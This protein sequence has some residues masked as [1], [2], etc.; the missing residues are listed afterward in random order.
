[1]AAYGLIIRIF[2]RPFHK[3]FIK[4]LIVEQAT[5]IERDLSLAGNFSTGVEI[6][7]KTIRPVGTWLVAFRD[8]TAPHPFHSFSLLKIMGAPGSPILKIRSESLSAKHEFIIGFD[9]RVNGWR[10]VCRYKGKYYFIP[11]GWNFV[12]RVSEREEPIDDVLVEAVI[13][14]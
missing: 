1:M 4:S 11:K 5:L 13:K 14:R 12:L 10:P 9:D 7:N 8:Q 2:Y 6:N 3:S